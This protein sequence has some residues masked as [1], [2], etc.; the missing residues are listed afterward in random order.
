MAIPDRTLCDIEANLSQLHYAIRISR[1]HFAKE[2]QVLFG[3]AQQIL[4]GSEL[5]RL[6]AM[7]ADTRRVVAR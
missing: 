5:D 7:W 2:E 3:I 1:D 6:G 4:A